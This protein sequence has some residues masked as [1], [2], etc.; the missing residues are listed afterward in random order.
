M[1][2][3]SAVPQDQVRP[4]L[5][6]LGIVWIVALLIALANWSSHSH[7]R[8][9]TSLVYSYAISTS[10]WFFSDPL[11]I[12]CS[13]WLRAPAPHY[14]A[15][16]ARVLGYMVLAAGL[17]IAV[18]DPFKGF[19]IATPEFEVIGRQIAGLGLP[20]LIV[21]EGGYP[22]PNLGL[23]LESLLKGLTR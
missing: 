10:I 20:A 5:R 1:S 21:Q 17:D 13:P 19:A 6:R 18:D 12:V 15:T 3:F 11:R 14:W 2:I 22:S 8:L 7:G 23:N 4:L 9:D 16:N